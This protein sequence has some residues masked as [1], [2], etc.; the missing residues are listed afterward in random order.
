MDYQRRRAILLSVS[1]IR[2]VVADDHTLTL[3]G[4]ADSLET[5]GVSVVGRAH[6]AA[7][8]VSLVE[9]KNPDAL[10]VDLDFGPGPTGLDIAASLRKNMPLL[11]IVL[12]SAYGDPRLHSGDLSHAPMGVV[13][14]IKQQVTSTRMLAEALTTAIE[15]AQGQAEGTLPRVNLTGGQITLLRLIAQGRS[16]N[17]IARDMSITEESVSKNINRM[18]KR[19]GIEPS[20]DTNTRAALL[21]S[22]FD[23]IGSNR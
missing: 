13:Y 8:A 7:E 10:L 5:H 4:V 9:R 3:M 15:K 14:L 22:Y 2:V 16:N 20:S 1:T 6:T 17:A 23:L 19:L 21:Q 12:L 18:V 11:G